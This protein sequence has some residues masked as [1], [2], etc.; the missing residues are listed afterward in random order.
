MKIRKATAQDCRFI[1]E[2]ALIA[3]DGIP[4][5]FWGKSQNKDQDIISVDASNA[6]SETE[7]F[8]YRNAHLAIVENA[9]A[10]I[11]LAYRL[12]DSRYAKRIEDFP[13]FILE[14]C[15]PNSFYINMLATQP[16]FRNKGVGTTLMS[17]VDK[18][19]LDTG[20]NLISIEVFE[21]NEGA[22]RLYQCLGYEVVEHRNI[23]RHSC[24]PYT[25]RVLLLTKDV[26]V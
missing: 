23:I 2:L 17:I 22:L 13:E 26:A 19:A 4:A 9:V 10:G 24:H 20:C 6:S 14:Q 12:P 8:S 25:G 18:L 11:L 21:Q 7:N 16:Q 5:Y 15:A 1:A 3:G